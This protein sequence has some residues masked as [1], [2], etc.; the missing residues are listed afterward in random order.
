MTGRQERRCRQLLDDLKEKRGQL[1]FKQE[2]PDRTVWL[3]RFARGCGPCRKT[4]YRM[5]MMVTMITSSLIPLCFN[6]DTHSANFS[7]D[8]TSGVYYS[9]IPKYYPCQGQQIL[10]NSR[11]TNVT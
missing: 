11:A 8:A 5:M 6:V 10:Q 3:T 1:K 7:L 4:D 9:F 2:A